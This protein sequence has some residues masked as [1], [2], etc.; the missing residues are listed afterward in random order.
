MKPHQTVMADSTVQSVQEKRRAS[1]ANMAQALNGLVSVDGDGGVDIEQ[2]RT[3]LEIP[4]YA[5]T[6]NTRKVAL[7]H[8]KEMC[9][10]SIFVILFTFTTLQGRNEQG[11]WL[12]AVVLSRRRCVGQRWLPRRRSRTA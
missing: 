11:A 12:S 7:S 3:K 10:Y 6:L 5:D 1:T 4:T 2:I 8:V 9:V